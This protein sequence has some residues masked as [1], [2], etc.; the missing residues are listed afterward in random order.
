MSEVAAGERASAGEGRAELRLAAGLSNVSIEART[1]MDRL[2]RGRFQGEIP[3]VDIDGSRVTIRSQ[4]NPLDALLALLGCRP[5]PSGEIAINADL[6]WELDI[7][8]GVS[9]VSADLRGARLESLEIAGGVNSVEIDLPR[10]SGAAR[11]EITGGVSRVTLR[12]PAGVPV[13]LQA[14]GGVSGLN[15]DGQ[16]VRMI[17]GAYHWQSPGF[18]PDAD[19][20]SLDV[21]GGVSGMTL[22]TR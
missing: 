21:R 17:G 11:V 2:V 8:G 16:R 10:P 20:Y 3:G 1:G 15:L 18:D 6:A 14:R 12:R 19:H 7:W 13:V 22:D 5:K 4:R 9:N